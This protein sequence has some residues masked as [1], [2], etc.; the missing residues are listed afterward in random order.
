MKIR[1]SETGHLHEMTTAFFHVVDDDFDFHTS[2]YTAVAYSQAS[3]WITK[4]TVNGSP[5]L[6][7][8]EAALI[9]C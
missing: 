5:A 3:L 7:L 9:S 1:F 2:D 6:N 8:I 4:A